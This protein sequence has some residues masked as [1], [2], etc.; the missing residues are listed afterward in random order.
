MQTL[1]ATAIDGR[2]DG[3]RAALLDAGLPI[4]DLDQSNGRFFRY[5]RSGVLTGFGGFEPYGGDALLRSV[6]VLPEA[7]GTG[8]G[9]Q[10]TSALLGEMRAGGIGR[11]YLLTD[12]AEAF[13]RHLSFAATPRETAPDAIRATKQ[14]TTICASAA[15][16]TRET[17]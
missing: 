14:A 7:R 8:A 17:A 10:I 2:D 16:L 4:D 9:R 12:T 15:M 13:F 11:A 6:V 5:E 1:G 3:L